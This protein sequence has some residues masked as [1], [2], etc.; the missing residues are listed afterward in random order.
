VRIGVIGAGNIGTALAR[1]LKPQGHELI[2]TYRR[3]LEKLERSAETFGVG[4]G[5]P[6]EPPA[7]ADVV[8]LAVTWGA[9][10]DAIAQAGDLSGRILWDCTNALLPDMR[11]LAI[12]TTTSGGEA[13]ARLAPRA[14]V[15]KG[16]P[17]MAE[18][19]HSDDPT[20]NGRPAGLFVAGDDAPAKSVVAG[21]MMGLPGEVIDAGDLSAARF[22]EPAMMLLVRLSYGLGR[23]PRVALRFDGEAA[24]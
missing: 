8:A 16:I 13:V 23:G 5:A 19:L 4:S 24:R 22:I 2:L 7:W 14:R 21:L 9:V 10:P 15:V 6:G 1:R 12:G 18:L 11:G 20:V 3:D 17:P